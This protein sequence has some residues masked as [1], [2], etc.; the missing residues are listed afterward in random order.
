[1]ESHTLRKDKKIAEGDFY[2]D[3]D[4]L[5]CVNVEKSIK[6]A[7][8]GIHNSRPGSPTSSN[9]STIDHTNGTPDTDSHELR[10]SASQGNLSSLRED[11]SIS[12]ALEA[13]VKIIRNEHFTAAL[14][15]EESNKHAR[16]ELGHWDGNSVVSNSR[17]V[18]ENSDV[19]EFVKGWTKRSVSKNLT[20]LLPADWIVKKA[21][22]VNKDSHSHYEAEFWSTR[23]LG[24]ETDQIEILSIVYQKISSCTDEDYEFT[25]GLYENM[26]FHKLSHDAFNGIETIVRDEDATSKFGASAFDSVSR[27]HFHFVKR[28]GFAEVDHLLYIFKPKGLNVMLCAFI[29]TSFG[30]GEN[31][32]NLVE[33]AAKSATIVYQ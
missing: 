27:Y 33:Y 21:Q 23:C 4:D 14:L 16:I 30:V 22:S 11:N 15:L 8:K 20:I 6:I 13:S 31:E 17:P 19:D 24:P 3:G 29:E 7:M 12:G 25:K 10:A 32:H 26:L 5:S 2:V 28:I 1:M 18:V 9:S